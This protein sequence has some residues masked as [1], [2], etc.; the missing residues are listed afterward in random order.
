MK[1]QQENLSAIPTTGYIR[2]YRL[3]ELLGFSLSTLDRKV[4]KGE[5]PKPT[6]LGEKITAFDAV[7]INHWLEERRGK[8]E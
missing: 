3:A 4:R 7:E 6:K 1:T 5:L 2:R 8:A